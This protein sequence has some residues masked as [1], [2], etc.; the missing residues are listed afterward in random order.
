M[1]VALNQ[2]SDEVAYQSAVFD[3]AKN[4]GIQ[5]RDLFELLYRILLG[6]NRGPRF[7]PFM[8]TI[9]KETVISE[10]KRALES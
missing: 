9:G 10:L 8:D 4:E 2:A 3:V 1:I 5:A 6:K 7:G